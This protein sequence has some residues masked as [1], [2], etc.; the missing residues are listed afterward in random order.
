MPSVVLE[1]GE[2]PASLNNSTFELARTPAVFSSLVLGGVTSL[3]GS[4]PAASFFFAAVSLFAAAAFFDLEA[5][6]LN[7]TA[8]D[9][10]LVAASLGACGHRP[11][12]TGSSV[13]AESSDF[14]TRHF[15]DE[16]P[17]ALSLV[18]VAAGASTW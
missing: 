2:G 13:A 5:T 6:A 7:F 17:E 14:G 3:A 11:G 9:F 18:A 12:E 16:R 4:S 8:E 10:L 1:C 15:N